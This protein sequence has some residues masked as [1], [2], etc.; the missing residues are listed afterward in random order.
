MPTKI[1]LIRHGEAYNPYDICYGRL[2]GFPLSEFGKRQINLTAQYF[3]NK[4]ITAIYTSPMLRTKQSAEII[5]SELTNVPVF[6]SR[7]LIEIKTSFEGKSLEITHAIN[8]DFY[9]SSQR[10]TSDE[11]M[12]QIA[13]RMKQ[14][15]LFALKKYSEKSIIAISHG[16]P[17]MILR[18][19]IKHLP[20]TL[21]SI[22]KGDDIKYIQHGE[23]YEITANDKNDL[24]IKSVFIPQI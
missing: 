3:I 18:A 11:T 17:C 10:G 8:D 4:Q 24:S 14:F 16:D 23:V 13:A 20:F 7:R 19:A 2:P 9:F 5:A 1:Y 21:P 12:E 15:V 6:I 22:G